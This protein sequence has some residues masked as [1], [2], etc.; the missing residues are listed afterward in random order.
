MDAREHLQRIV[1]TKEDVDRFLGRIAT[2]DGYN[3][4]NGYIYD[5]ELGWVFTDA[6]IPA[7]GINGSHAFYHFETT[8]ARRRVSFAEMRSRIH[9]YGDSFTLCGQVND[10]ETWQE[11][12]AAHLQEPIE[13][14]GVSGYSVYQAYRRMMKVEAVHPAKYIIL[15]IYDDDHFRN[16]DPWRGIRAGRS[17]GGRGP[18]TFTLPHVRVDIGK[19]QWTEIDNLCPTEDHLYKLTDINWV[20]ETFGNDPILRYALAINNAG[21]EQV[22]PPQEIPVAFGLP[23]A[24]GS[25]DEVIAEIQNAH[26]RASM[27]ATQKIV[28]RIE[29]FVSE[30]GRKLMLILTCRQQNLKTYLEG[31]PSW[32]QAFL[33]FLKTRDYPVLDMRDFHLEDFRHWRLDVDRYL[34]RYY[35]GHYAPAGNFFCAMSI[36][37]AVVNWLDPRPKPYK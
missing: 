18:N 36:R 12:L 5:P 6:V 26:A 25:D 2:E 35:I 1:P 28:E 13:N 15:N 3:C 37:D 22:A 29:K 31:Q 20:L 30:T 11:Y 9:T 17:F 21:H 14:F 32:D 19:N 7:D 33:D 23:A 24:S 34:K 10:G 16:L 8:G 4:N 27:F